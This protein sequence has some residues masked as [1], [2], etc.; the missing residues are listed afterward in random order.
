MIGTITKR[1]RRDGKPAWGYSFFAGRSATGKRIQ[2]TKSGFDSRKA[3]ADALRKAIEQ[4]RSEAGSARPIRFTAFLDRWLDEYAS[5]RCTPKTLER[6]RQLGQHA[7]KYLGDTQLE[8]LAPVAIE[9]MLNNLLKSGGPK[10]QAHPDGRPLSARTARHVAFLIHDSLESAVR[11]GILA[12]NPMDRVVLPKEERKEVRAPDKQAL[13]RLLSAV[14]GTNLFPLFVMAAST[15]CRRGELLALEW[16]DIDFQTGIIT[17]SKSLEQTKLGLRVKSTKSGKARRFPLPSVALGVLVQHR[18]NQRL[19]NPIQPGSKDVGL[20]FCNPEGDYHK[21]DQISSR[22]AEITAKAGLRG[23]SLHSL[24]HGHASQLLS[25]GVPIPTVSKRLGHANPA[26]TLKLY[27]HALESD[28]SA[29]AQRWD[30]AFAKVVTAH[31]NPCG[32]PQGLRDVHSTPRMPDLLPS[33]PHE[34]E[35]LQEGERKRR[36]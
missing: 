26:I 12:V 16:K 33:L 18:R 5:H 27:S 1:A 21:P 9:S 15:G 24:R 3:A 14:S 2:I 32:E 22:V 30:S 31:A 28:E 17:I 10:D 35:Q 11:W 25:E 36:S 13:S 19:E 7:K 34:V 23:M 8:S 4:H 29:A 20:V 6:Y